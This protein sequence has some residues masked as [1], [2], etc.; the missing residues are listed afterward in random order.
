[1]KR[2]CFQEDIPI[3]IG[4]YNMEFH[5]SLNKIIIVI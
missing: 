1:M 2:T 3:T 5:I 4:N